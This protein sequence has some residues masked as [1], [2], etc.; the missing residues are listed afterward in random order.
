MSLYIDGIIS[1]L[2][3][4]SIIN[5]LL[6]LKRKP[7]KMLEIKVAIAGGKKDAYLEIANRL[8][9]LRG[10]SVNLANPDRLMGS[11]ISSSDTGVL[12]V[13]GDPAAAAGTHLIRVGRLAQNE[14][15]VSS[16]FA[17]TSEI[18]L[19][20]GTLTI[21]LGGG[22]VE[23][24]TRLS[25]LNGGQGVEAG[26][27]R[28]T[29]TTNA[30]ATVDL[31]MALDTSDV[32]KAINN[33]GIGVEAS[34]RGGAFVLKDTT[35][36]V[37]NIVVAE[38]GGG[39][40]ATD[41]GIEGNSGGTDTLT[42]GVVRTVSASTRISDLNDGRGVRE[43]A[44]DD[45]TITAQAATFSL[46]ISFA[47]TLGDVVDLINNDIA[48][49]GQVTASIGP[50]GINLV[51]NGW[52]GGAFSVASIGGSDTALDLG[53]EQSV[54]AANINGEDIISGL[55]SV[56]LSSLN[57][58]SGIGRGTIDI[59][60][61]SGAMDTVDLTD[62]A[63]IDEVI[64]RINE[65]SVAITASVNPSGDGI[66]LTDTSGGAGAF[67]VVDNSATAAADLGINTGVLGVNQDEIDSDDLNFQY[68]S[69]ATRLDSLNG[70]Q[71]AQAGKI[72]ITDGAGTSVTIDLSQADDDTIA[73]VID[74]INGVGTNIIASI[75]AAG[76][77]ILLTDTSGSGVMTIAE[78]DGGR[79]ARDLNI[80][81]SS[82]SGTLDGSF[83]FSVD[84]DATDNLLSVQQKINALGI[85]VTAS[86]FS[87]GS[88]TDP[89][90]LAL[91]G[92]VSGSQ[93]RVLVNG[94]DAG[95]DFTR[96]SAARDA[97]L[98]Y[99]DS[100]PSSLLISK[101]TNIINDLVEGLT[102]TLKSVSDTP[103]TIGI[104]RDATQAVAKVQD[105]VNV[106]NEVLEMLDGLSVFDIDPAKRG[107][108]QGETTVRRIVRELQRAILNPTS[109][110]G[111]SYTLASQIGIRIG[112]DGRLTFDS[113]KFTAAVED[114]PE[115]VLKFF[116][117]TRN[118]E[119]MVKLE[120]F[121][122]GDGVEI[123]PGVADFKVTRKDGVQLIV[124][125]TGAITL[126]DVLDMINNHV[127]NADGKLVAGIAADGKRL[128]ITDTT[129]G[130]GD[131]SVTAM[132]GSHAFADLGLNLFTSG[133]KI[134]GS[135][136]TL[137]DPPGI[138][139]RLVSV[140]DFLTD[141]DSGTIAHRTETLD[142]DVARYEESIEKYESRLARE[143][144][145]L[146]RQFTML[147]QMMGEHQNTLLQLNS[148][149]SAMT[150]MLRSNR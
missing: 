78:V 126:A 107:I 58:G 109:E 121:A 112:T 129:G 92:D 73:D 47:E 146:R 74:E 54:T 106:L 72:Q 7:I 26:S 79:T 67:I 45:L 114:D 69:R 95:V 28:I 15:R 63:T 65:A 148:T 116:S 135:E 11:T 117:A 80:A 66:L 16:G 77:G 108:L 29:D 39:T 50:R 91:M 128:Q 149:L 24:P 141:V 100:L 98:R 103:V 61:R 88:A 122:D 8:L 4:T 33:A 99:G 124:D 96:T 142:S 19:P 18:G 22:F 14:Q 55:E 115:S 140:L 21:E 23:N 82:S 70:G 143:E 48:N 87:D 123:L 105:F 93:A 31:S 75:N 120:D 36:V 125:L 41:L 12:T 35:G 144:E 6:A 37:G 130:G 101:S 134:I 89:F 136:I 137:T 20:T 51:D 81:G 57:G 64:A 40:T 150:D 132:N 90:H 71:G 56:L 10:R 104:T 43:I 131:L 118:L 49:G 27:I 97:V 3:T 145:R 2:D 25:E 13:S 86:I 76:N 83:E 113:A 62:A 94:L 85:S 84:I 68:I 147:E 9:E 138:G 139:H 110:T 38:I 133:T 34:V 111:G 44:G 102:I 32:I 52:I 1:G 60:D 127:N 53:I 119:Q 42:G 46:D 5:E 59:T 30:S 17:S